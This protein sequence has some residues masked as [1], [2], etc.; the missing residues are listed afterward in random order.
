[1][2]GY[3]TN[4]TM[5]MASNN[6]M[7]SIAFSHGGWVVRVVASQ[8]LKTVVTPPT[9]GSNPTRVVSIMKISMSMQ[10]GARCKP[11]TW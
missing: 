11:K 5:I 3:D 7:L 8:S 1:M 4:N 6:I 10:D 9:P 2:M